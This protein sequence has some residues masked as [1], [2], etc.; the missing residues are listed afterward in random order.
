MNDKKEEAL[1]RSGESE[2]SVQEPTLSKAGQPW[3][4]PWDRETQVAGDQRQRE[5]GRD[6]DEGVCRAYKAV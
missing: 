3:Q 4:V 6:R 5:V 1:G 2:I